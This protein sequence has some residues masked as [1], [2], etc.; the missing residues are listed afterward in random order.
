MGIQY[1]MTSLSVSTCR[2]EQGSWYQ[3][4]DVFGVAEGSRAREDRGDGSFRKEAEIPDI[5]EGVSVRTV[6][7][8]SSSVITTLTMTI[9]PPV[10]RMQKASVVEK[11]SNS[12]GYCDSA[13]RLNN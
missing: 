10:R 7:L 2:V 5:F 13:L 12:S 1:P 3:Q 4:L 11:I 6:G 8:G 9:P